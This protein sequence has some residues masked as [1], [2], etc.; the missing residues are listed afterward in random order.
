MELPVFAL[1][2]PAGGRYH[3]RM[4]II[5]LVVVA[6]ALLYVLIHKRPVNNPVGLADPK[7][8]HAQAQQPAQPPVLQPG[9]EL[10]MQQPQANERPADHSW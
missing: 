3:A 6:A 8:W 2:S 4:L 5:V 10:M 7:T 9:I 1:A